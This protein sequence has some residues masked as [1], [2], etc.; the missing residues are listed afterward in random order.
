MPSNL[1]NN[2][3]VSY[4]GVR[5]NTP[6]NLYKAKRA[7]NANDKKDIGSF[8]LN[9]VSGVNYQLTN[10][11]SGVPNWQTVTGTQADVNSLTGGSGT[12]NPVGGNIQIA[13]TANQ[14]TS[15]ASGS[16]VTL[17]LPSAISASGSITAA[18]T[19]TATSGN[20]T[21]TNGN[22]VLN[23]VGNKLLINAGTNCSVG[24][25]TLGGTVTTA[26]SN[27]DVTASSLIYLQTLTLGTV[28][29][30]STLAV[31]T[32]SA[33]SGFTVKPSQATDTSTVAFLIIN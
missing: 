21:A 26:V 5:P 23:S 11:S 10:Y 6:P 19:L 31:T 18:T 27:T 3:P 17:A 2:N 28:S 29:A 32:I 22:L 15:T 8:W 25:F 14:I 9:T 20:I 4:L 33:G 30:A 12:A 16:T 1:P 7:P 24:T 13:G